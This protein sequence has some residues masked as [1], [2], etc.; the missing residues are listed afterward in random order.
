MVLALSIAFS[1]KVVPVSSTSRVHPQC[2][3]ADHLNAQLAQNCT[4]LPDFI[5]IVGCQY[6]FHVVPHS[7][8]LSRH[9]SF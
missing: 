5:G 4:H 8:V 7:A 2:P 6:E 3:G 1:A 9:V